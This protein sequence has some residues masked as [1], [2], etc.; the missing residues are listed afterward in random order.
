MHFIRRVSLSLG[1][2]GLVSFAAVSAPLVLANIPAERKVIQVEQAGKLKVGESIASLPSIASEKDRFVAAGNPAR[3]SLVLLKRNLPSS[4]LNLQCS[5]LASKVLAQ[6]GLLIG[7]G[8]ENFFREAGLDVGA[9]SDASVLIVTDAAGKIRS[10]YRNASM[11]DL[12]G[13]LKNL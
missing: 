7:G 3:F 4:C 6:G 2:V 13:I 12:H 8:D 11:R 10:I 5:A 9:E 1:F